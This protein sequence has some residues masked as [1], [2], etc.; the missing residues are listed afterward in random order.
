MIGRPNLL[1]VEDMVKGFPD[2][3]LFQ[4]AQNPSGEIPQFLLV[5]EIQR[6][7]NMRKDYEAQ[8]Q[9]PENT[10]AEQIMQQGIAA[11]V[12]N[13]PQMSSMSQQNI[14][15][16]PPQMP[17]QGMPPQQQPMMPMPPQMPPQQPQMPNMGMAQGGVVRMANGGVP[18]MMTGKQ[19]SYYDRGLPISG[20][21]DMTPDQIRGL[22]D[23][24]IVS[25]QQEEAMRLINDL[26]MYSL[27]P[28]MQGDIG[29]MDAYKDIVS[30]YDV[31]DYASTTDVNP[32]QMSVQDALQQ[33][34]DAPSAV[35]GLIDEG[36]ITNL[37]VAG[38]IPLSVQS[39]PRIYP[40]YTINKNKEFVYENAPEGYIYP[41]SET[42][43]FDTPITKLRSLGAKNSSIGQQ[44]IPV[45]ESDVLR[46]KL[47]IARAGQKV[48]DAADVGAR[49]IGALADV[50]EPYVDVRDYLGR[51]G[52]RVG[53]VQGAFE[54]EGI[55]AGLG[56]LVR[57]VG[58]QGIDTLKTYLT[59]A[60]K[61]RKDVG[62]VA[63][64]FVREDVVPA[65]EE[66]GTQLAYG[67]QD[68]AIVDAKN[69]A[70][71]SNIEQLRSMLPDMSG[72]N[73][74]IK[75]LFSGM[76][77]LFGSNNNKSVMGISPNQNITKNLT[78][79]PDINN[80]TTDNLPIY[81]AAQENNIKPVVEKE[82]TSKSITGNSKIQAQARN[83]KL[84]QI[85]S[86]IAQRNAID[87][88]RGLVG[89][90]NYGKVPD[91]TDLIDEYKDDALSNALINLG[92][93]I[94]GG[95][96]SGGLTRAGASALESRRAARDLR[97]QQLVAEQALQQEGKSRDI[98]ILSSI[99]KIEAERDISSAVTRRK[100]L[101][102]LETMYEEQMRL[103]AATFDEE[104]KKRIDEII[105]RIQ[106]AMAGYGLTIPNPKTKKFG[107]LNT[108]NII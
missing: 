7:S 58:G 44:S 6:R 20:I 29:E 16:M 24:L 32:M 10:V 102:V 15:P 66:F 52:E 76:P 34:G 106:S 9:Q 104:E 67:T 107:E 54:E 82:A 97:K 41:E 37:D 92:A 21:S 94:A 78:N 77:S 103:R 93:G 25:G 90:K 64:D 99:A 68:P 55:P 69:K 47:A 101:Q 48:S 30:Q 87:E 85:D 5:S 17:P 51:A 23:N 4:Q 27:N 45:T 13:Q 61:V 72:S 91:M 57:S 1:E 80:L 38:N 96:L 60:S 11:S 88:L 33:Y 28:A 98:D 105:T 22:I 3:T 71:M 73:V 14:A 42:V 19:F 70:A 26:R 31:G 63:A 95:D 74:P 59:G 2:Q 100:N 86:N 35:E 39:E 62:D 46:E 56:Q 49:G 36:G 75:D 89:A 83:D 53:A 84:D 12:P 81:K 108:G 79:T 40:G 65:A 18:D 43:G 50:V 8:Q